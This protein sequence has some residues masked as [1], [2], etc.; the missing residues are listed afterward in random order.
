M[1]DARDRYLRES[2]VREKT[3][4]SFETLARFRRYEGHGIDWQR[5]GR[6]ARENFTQVYMDT[7]DGSMSPN[8]RMKM[9]FADAAF[10]PGGNINEGSSLEVESLERFYPGA[11]AVLDEVETV[12]M[13]ALTDDF[14][15]SFS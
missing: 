4:I 10:R 11:K 2:Q 1:K 12:V 7:Y 15:L 5:V 8:D 14:K 3:N 6:Y 13:T 9:I